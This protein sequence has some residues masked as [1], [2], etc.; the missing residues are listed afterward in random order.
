MKKYLVKSFSFLF[1]LNF[2][3][4][5][6]CSSSSF[7]EVSAITIKEDGS[8]VYC[9]PTTSP[10][11]LT[12]KVIDNLGF[13]PGSYDWHENDDWDWDTYA[14][15]YGY[16]IENKD[17]TFYL[18]PSGG[19]YHP[20]FEFWMPAVNLGACSGFIFNIDFTELLNPSEL[21]ISLVVNTSSDGTIGDVSKLTKNYPNVGSSGYYYDYELGDWVNTL[22]DSESYITLPDNYCGYVYMPLSSYPNILSSDF[23]QQYHMDFSIA[24][25]TECVNPVYFDDIDM[26]SETLEHTHVYSFDKTYSATCYSKGLDLMKCS[27]GQV[28]WN[29]IVNCLSH[30]VG[31]KFY[32]SD[33]LTA[34]LCNTCDSLIYFEEE[35]QNKLTDGASITY[36]YEI[37]EVE[38]IYDETRIYPKGYTLK[39]TDIPYKFYICN[40]VD[41]WQLFR[42]TK[43]DKALYGL[44]PLGLTVSKDLTLY[45]QYN[46]ASYDGEKYR[47]MMSDVSLNGG[48][49]DETTYGK[50]IVYVGQSNFSLWHDMELWYAQKGFVARNNSVAGAT[51][52]NY[53]EFVEE[54]VLMYKPKIVVVIVS[55]ND[56]AYHN[57]TEKTVMN[58]MI[59]FYNRIN[60]VLP[61]TQVIFVSGN[62]LP[63]RNEYFS[64]IKRINAKLEAF[65][66]KYDN[67]YYVDIYDKTMEFVRAYPVGWETWTHLEHEHLVKLMGDEIYSVMKNVIKEKNIRF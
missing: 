33:N 2:L 55:S 10:N 65:T 6:I 19:M 66:K 35:C 22:I 9:R 52:H 4:L 27:C 18:I 30:N 50:K 51:S 31:E 11:N 34:A 37:D 5:L 28:K 61:E 48:P 53:V 8:N 25:N 20:S 58:N 46:F 63:G 40:G 14:S 24:D 56:L 17:Y 39:S 7:T 15:E 3:F 67:T 54:L 38:N 57:M 62:P 16:N 44:N 49:Y 23:V 43:D 42:Y 29:N 36:K 12:M 45:A 13:E 47:A 41:G 26:V 64:V 59:E 1:V 60:E 32:C 21:K